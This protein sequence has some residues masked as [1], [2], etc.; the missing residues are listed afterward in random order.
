MNLEYARICDNMKGEKQ[1][2]QQKE[3]KLKQEE[4]NKRQL[5]VQ[6][7]SSEARERC[8]FLL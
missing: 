6:I 1:I 2:E 7:L 8:M 5:L 4:E 3:Q